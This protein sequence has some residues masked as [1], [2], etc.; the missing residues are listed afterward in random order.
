M[1]SVYGMKNDVFSTNNIFWL[2]S[3]MALSYRRQEWIVLDEKKK[4]KIKHNDIINFQFITL[5]I[6]FSSRIFIFCTPMSNS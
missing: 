5:R 4:E 2:I 3:A 1:Y 6:R